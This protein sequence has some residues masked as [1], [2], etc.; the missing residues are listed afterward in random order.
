MLHLIEQPA[1]PGLRRSRRIHR[2]QIAR[3]AL[4]EVNARQVF[5]P[6]TPPVL[7]FDLERLDKQLQVSIAGQSEIAMVEDRLGPLEQGSE[8]RDEDMMRTK[9]VLVVIVA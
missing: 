1:R 8:W 9:A 5:G 6:H 3:P 4:L 2:A 7:I